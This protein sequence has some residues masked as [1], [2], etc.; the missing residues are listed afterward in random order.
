MRRPMLLG[1]GIQL[2]DQLSV[3]ASFEICID[4]SFDCRHT[5]FRESC[6]FR[7][8]FKETI[9]ICVR[10]SSPHGERLSENL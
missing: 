3:M 8:E 2:G 1:E 10:M 4:P 7:R 9:N 6:A 5:Q